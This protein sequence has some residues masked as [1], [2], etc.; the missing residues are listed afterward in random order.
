MR[1]KTD[2]VAH[3]RL[4]HAYCGE[5]DSTAIDAPAKPRHERVLHVRVASNV[6]PA[7]QNC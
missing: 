7:I 1:K 2:G 4:L 5:V 6:Y 3:L